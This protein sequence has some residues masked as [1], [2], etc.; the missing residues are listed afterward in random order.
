MPNLIKNI[1]EENPPNGKL[2]IFFRGLCVFYIDKPKNQQKETTKQATKQASVPIKVLLPDARIP[3]N[4]ISCYEYDVNDPLFPHIPLL[5]IPK[6]LLNPLPQLKPHKFIIEDEFVFPLTKHIIDVGQ[7]DSQLKKT[8]DFENFIPNLRE[9]VKD[10]KGNPININPDLLDPTKIRNHNKLSA[11]LEIKTGT[12][13]IP[14]SQNT[15]PRRAADFIKTVFDTDN[16]SAPDEKAQLLAN[17]VCWDIDIKYASKPKLSEKLSENSLIN[18]ITPLIEK[19]RFQ[20]KVTSIAE[21]LANKYSAKQSLEEPDKSLYKQLDEKYLKVDPT[22]FQQIFQQIF[23]QIAKELQDKNE[24]K[25]QDE[26]QDIVELVAQHIA[27]KLN[28]DHRYYPFTIKL[29]KP[30]D[31]NAELTLELQL[32]VKI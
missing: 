19:N 32:K 20:S 15:D 30:L 22:D 29:K 13:S 8:K 5:S 17:C 16:T 11:L 1:N 10:E 2:R 26:Y 7:T 3:E 27:A 31:L 12:I 18:L 25:Y 24:V 14:S 4:T 23:K 6:E 21:T 9:Y 28:P